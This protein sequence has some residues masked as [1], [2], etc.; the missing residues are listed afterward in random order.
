ML[1]AMGFTVVKSVFTSPYTRRAA[2]KLNFK[3]LYRLYFQE[4]VN[5]KGIRCFAHAGPEDFAAVMA[6]KIN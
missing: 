3:E 6:L 4:F 1:Q 5:S 2:Q